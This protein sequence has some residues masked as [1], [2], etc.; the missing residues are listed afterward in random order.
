MDIN[1]PACEETPTPFQKRS[2]NDLRSH[3]TV[4]KCCVSQMGIPFQHCNRYSIFRHK[5]FRIRFLSESGF[6]GQVSLHKL[7]LSVLTHITQNIHHNTK[8]YNSAKQY[9]STDLHR[10]PA[11]CQTRGTETRGTETRGTETRG[12][13]TRGT[14]TRGVV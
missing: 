3:Q 1:L 13:D 4:L 10:D 7:A 5:D 8:Q 6:I 2:V 9:N 14:E 11:Q 12:T